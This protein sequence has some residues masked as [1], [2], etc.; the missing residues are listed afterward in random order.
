MSDD[1]KS[2]ELWQKKIVWSIRPFWRPGTSQIKKCLGFWFLRF[3][4]SWFRGFFV[5]KFQ[6]SEDPKLLQRFKRWRTLNAFAE[7][8]DPVL[9]N[10]HLIFKIFT[11]ILSGSL[12]FVGTHLFQN[13]QYCAFPKN[14]GNNIF[15]NESVLFLNCLE[16][17][18]VSKATNNWFRESWARPE[19]WK[20][21]KSWVFC[22]AQKEIGKLLVQ[23]EAE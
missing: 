8:I 9:P 14:V 22:L 5:S 4:V 13:V 6:S 11:E 3:L 17:P 12:G 20:S 10:F 15:R 7:D 2:G 16:Y 21:W 23:N 19:I 1:T 18:G